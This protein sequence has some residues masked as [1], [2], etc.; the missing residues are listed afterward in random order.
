MPQSGLHARDQRFGARDCQTALAAVSEPLV[1]SGRHAL[2]VIY[3]RHVATNLLRGGGK[4]LGFG[5][6]ACHTTGVIVIIMLL[7]IDLV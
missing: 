7:E 1:N 4:K 6:E 3:V 2:R 5:T